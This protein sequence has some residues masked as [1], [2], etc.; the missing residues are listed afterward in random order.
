MR[1]LPVKTF[2]V[3]TW[4]VLVSVLVQLLLAGLGVFADSGFFFWH[5]TV[6]A[7]V[8]FLLPLLLVLLGWLGRVPGRIL[9]LA[10]AVPGLTLVQSLLLAPYH[11]NAQGVLRAVSGLHVLNAVLI[12]WVSIQLVEQTRTWLVGASPGTAH[13]QAAADDAPDAASDPAP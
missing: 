5:A 12:F 11:M 10:A 1:E 8:V 9:W 7:G 6:N 2:S 4:L 3:G 13:Q